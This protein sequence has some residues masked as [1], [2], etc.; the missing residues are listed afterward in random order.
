MEIQQRHGLG[1]PGP[2][3]YNCPSSF[4]PQ[5]RLCFVKVMFVLYML[6]DNNVFGNSMGYCLSE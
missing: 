1:T 2:G 6:Y 4:G 3:T 5:V